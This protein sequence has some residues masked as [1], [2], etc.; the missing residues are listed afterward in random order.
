MAISCGF[1]ITTLVVYLLLRKKQK[2]HIWVVTSYIVSL[3]LLNLFFGI[4]N[5]ITQVSTMDGGMTVMRGSLACII[6]GNSL[7]T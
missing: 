3:L 1:L 7:E 2:F 5:L 4:S 6:V